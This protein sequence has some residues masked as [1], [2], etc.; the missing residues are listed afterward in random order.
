[1]QSRLRWVFAM[2]GF[3]VGECKKQPGERYGVVPVAGVD[4]F[5]GEL[6][7]MISRWGQGELMAQTVLGLASDF[8]EIHLRKAVTSLVVRQ[9][10]DIPLAFW[11]KKHG[12]YHMLLDF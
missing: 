11:R 10:D 4:A 1:M 5:A 2:G 12:D 7:P 8:K 9:S 6:I 3:K